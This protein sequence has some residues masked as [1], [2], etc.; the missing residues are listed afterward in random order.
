MAMAIKA[1]VNAYED[2]LRDTLGKAVVE[3]DLVEKHRK[4]RKGAFP[5]LRGTYWRWAQTIGE[6]C[7]DLMAAPPVLAIGDTHVENFGCWRDAE[8]RLAWGANDF[9]DAAVMPWPLD[10]AR[11]AA[12]ALLARGDLGPGAGD[13]CGPLLRGYKAGL[14]AP[15]PFI[16]DRDHPWLRRAARLPEDERKDYWDKYKDPDQSQPSDEPYRRR[17]LEALPEPSSDV[18]VFPHQA[19]LG[20]LGRPRFVARALWRGGPVLREAKAVVR[21]A[22]TLEHGGDPAIRIGEIA[23]GAFRAVD[24]HYR[25]ADGI[26]VRRLSPNSRK[27]EARHGLDHLLHPEMLE[28]MGHEIANCHRGDGDRAAAIRPHLDRLPRDWLRTAAKAAARQV[29][30][31]WKAFD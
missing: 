3:V 22:W 5:F 25:C 14:D 19:G 4:M 29:E 20:S 8:G 6:V 23:A 17:L 1:S 15:A 26:V 12:S 10:L 11:L 31:D 13:I 9:D 30:A 21:S 16:L 7:P 18:A 2:W 27:I 24:P 28:A